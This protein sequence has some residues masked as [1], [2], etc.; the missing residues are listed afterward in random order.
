MAGKTLVR[1]MLLN[2]KLHKA[3]GLAYVRR[4]GYTNILG[5]GA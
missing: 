4:F 1:M 2:A 3:G 5:Y